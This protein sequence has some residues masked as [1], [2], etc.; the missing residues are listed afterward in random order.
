MYA[1]V[2]A[3]IAF[4]DGEVQDS[5]MILSIQLEDAG[6]MIRMEFPG[7]SV[8]PLEIL[9]RAGMSRMPGF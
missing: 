4:P 3:A 1:D 2:P 6:G 8:T 5:H 7:A 9:S